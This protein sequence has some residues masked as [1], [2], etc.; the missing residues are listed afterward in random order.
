MK[1]SSLKRR[2]ES[3]LAEKLVGRLQIYATEYTRAD[4]DIGRGWITLDG[5]E[6]VSVV[7]P[8]IYDAQM[9][10]EVKD[11]NFGRAIG[12]YVNLPFDKI[13]E[14]K[15]PIIQGL[16]FLDKRYGKRLLRDAKT[17]DLHNFSLILYKLRCKVEGIECEISNHSNPDV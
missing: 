8:S 4:I 1:W 11:F 5:M 15:D 7:V 12:E 17:Q 14:S 9:R 6:V 10:F 13:K 2:F 16:A 3:L